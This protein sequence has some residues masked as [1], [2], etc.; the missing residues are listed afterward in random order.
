MT[1]K[2]IITIS[3]QYG[4]GG[5]YIGSLLAKEL[6]IPFY[7]KE[8]ITMAAQKS[9]LDKDVL[10]SV[11]EHSVPSLFYSIPIGVYGLGVDRHYNTPINDKLFDIQSQIIKEVAAKGSC[12]IVGRCADYVLKD[13]PHLLKVFF[14]GE[15]KNR[16][17]RGIKYYKL[18]PEKAEK[19]ILRED[20]QRAAYYDYYVGLKWGRVNNYHLCLDGDF[21]PL[22]V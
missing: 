7:D 14:S 16:I 10:S 2:I 8:L 5:R 6:N 22:K 11:D 15:L 4:S 9:G 3:R 13:D 12:V 20:K 1:E 21:L 17:N 19:I 18:L